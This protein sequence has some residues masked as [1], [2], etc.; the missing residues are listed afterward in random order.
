MISEVARVIRWRSDGGV[1]AGGAE[2]GR[3]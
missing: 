1:E 3:P 2:A